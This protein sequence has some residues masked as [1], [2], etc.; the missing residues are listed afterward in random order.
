MVKTEWEAPAL[1]QEYQ[2]LLRH[3]AGAQQRC[4]LQLAAQQR[5]IERLQGEVQRLQAVL[6]LRDSQLAL[7]RA[8]APAPRPLLRQVLGQLPLV[9]FRPL[10]PFGS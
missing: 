3:C 10:G 9:G 1:A 8:P 2:A 6:V 4:S 7:V 5:E